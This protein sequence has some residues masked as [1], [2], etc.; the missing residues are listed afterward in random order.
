MNKMIKT[1]NS[2]DNFVKVLKKI[3]FI[4][5]IIGGIALAAG[6]IF[7]IV[8]PEI[9]LENE[10]TSVFGNGTLMIKL[11]KE[12]VIRKHSF[13]SICINLIMSLLYTLISYFALGYIRNI[14][15]PMKD[16]LLF[17]NAV[18]FN[19]K[20]LAYITI[21]YGIVGNLSAI[22]DLIMFN[23][24]T[25]FSAITDS[26]LIESI[27]YVYVFDYKFLIAFFVLLFVSYVF[28]YGE[29]FQQKVDD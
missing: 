19:I 21:F 25:D 15:Q 4:I 14:L 24:F 16:G 11:A 6:L 26:G 1:A 10:A 9:A 12:C 2:V 27:K 13:I 22:I 28:R 8:V 7:L 29:S 3:D 17:D 20:K 5:L 18:S 23:H